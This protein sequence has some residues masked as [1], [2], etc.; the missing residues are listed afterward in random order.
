[1]KGPNYFK[2]DFSKSIMNNKSY[3]L[4]LTENL[5][6]E[7]LNSKNIEKKNKMSKLNI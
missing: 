3:Q 5:G 2:P 7:E 4:L 6:N 1:M